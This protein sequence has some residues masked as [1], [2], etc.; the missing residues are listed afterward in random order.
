MSEKNL[1]TFWKDPEKRFESRK[2]AEERSDHPSGGIILPDLDDAV[3]GG[4]AWLT[5]GVAVTGA[6][7]CFT[8]NN[9]ACNG[10]CGVRTSGCCG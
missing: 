1:L 8:L 9:T 2:V 4:T 7:G 10:T 6:F 5:P 3:A